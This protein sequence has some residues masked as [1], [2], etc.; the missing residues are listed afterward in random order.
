MDAEDRLLERRNDLWQELLFQGYDSDDAW[1]IA[2]NET[3]LSSDDEDSSDDKIERER[4]ED[5]YE[6]DMELDEDDGFQ[7]HSGETNQVGGFHRI[8]SVDVHL[9]QIIDLRRHWIEMSPH[10]SVRAVEL[11]IHPAR[12][13]EIEVSSSS[14]EVPPMHHIDTFVRAVVTYLRENLPPDDHVQL[15]LVSDNLPNGGVLTH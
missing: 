6:V 13:L 14:G 10:F 8:A 9:D 2:C 7:D 5:E 1:D 12:E 3:C 15:E 4:M 11:R